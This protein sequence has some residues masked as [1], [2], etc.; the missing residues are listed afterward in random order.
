MF[1]IQMHYLGQH[2]WPR[3]L[4]SQFFKGTREN[5][6]FLLH[7][8]NALLLKTVDRFRSLLFQRL[9]LEGEKFTVGSLSTDTM[10]YYSVSGVAARDRRIYFNISRGN[11]R[12]R[13]L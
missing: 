13:D 12:S 8:D 9:C 2:R 1:S 7:G 5:L 6:L 3:L 10:V 11:P 4:N